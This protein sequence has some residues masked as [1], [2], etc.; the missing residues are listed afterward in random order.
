M[1]RC[2][3]DDRERPVD[4]VV[5]SNAMI[6]ETPQP[7]RRRRSGRCGVLVM[8]WNYTPWISARDRL[9][10]ISSRDRPTPSIR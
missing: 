3:H 4:A 9:V 7:V 8:L 10:G 2:E 5:Y 6:G 1:F